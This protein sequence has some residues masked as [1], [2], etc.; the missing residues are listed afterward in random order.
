MKAMPN[1][2]ARAAKRLLCEHK[3]ACKKLGT[4]ALS[5]NPPPHWECRDRWIPEAHGLAFLAKAVGCE[6]GERRCLKKG[7]SG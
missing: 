7:R 4:A 2:T 3:D 5:H 6:C 1:N